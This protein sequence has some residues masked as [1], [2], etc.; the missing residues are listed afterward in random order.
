MSGTAYM[1]PTQYDV[2]APSDKE[3][4]HQAE[5]P[6]RL[7][8]EILEAIS[9]PG[10][11]V[12]DQYCGAGGVGAAALKKGRFSVLFEI[13]RENVEKISKR[14]GATAIYKEHLIED[15]KQS[16]NSVPI[17]MVQLSLF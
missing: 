17:E 15:R 4:L 7:Y 5:K 14:L 11:L 9:L 6:L 13:L 10:E 1:L 12:I 8:E 3:R 16:A 2:Q